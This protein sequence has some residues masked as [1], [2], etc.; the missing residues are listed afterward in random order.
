[1]SDFRYIGIHALET[2]IAIQQ[3]TTD[4]SCASVDRQV[5]IFRVRF[6]ISAVVHI[7]S[8]FV[9]ESI[10]STV[11]RDTRPGVRSFEYIYLVHCILEP[12]VRIL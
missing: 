6:T 8:L 3:H 7:D 4:P 11:I 10:V 1:M 5:L 12:I 9:A 2:R